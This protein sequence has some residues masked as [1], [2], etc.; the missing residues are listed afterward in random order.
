M[1]T[2]RRKLSIWFYW[3]IPLLLVATWY[4]TRSLDVD[5]YWSDEV[6]TAQRAGIAWYAPVASIAE[7]WDRTQTVSDQLPLY[8]ILVGLWS[9]VAGTTPF[10]NRALS[11]FFGII[12]IATTFQIGKRLSG[13]LAGFAAALL[14][15]SSA[16]YILFLHE[17]RTYTWVSCLIALQLWF[18][19]LIIHG[20]RNWWVQAGL[21]LCVAAMLYSYYTSIII[22]AS[23]CLY[24]LL[25]VRKN[26]EWWRVVMLMGI[27]GIL[28]IPW[29]PNLANIAADTGRNAIRTIHTVSAIDGIVNMASAFSNKNNAALLFLL[30]F[31]LNL[32][33]KA[34]RF[35][36]FINISVLTLLVLLNQPLGLLVNVRYSLLIWL[37]L[38][39]LVGLGVEQLVKVGVPLVL[40]LGV[41]FASGFV[42]VTNQ[43]LTDEYD[44]PV[45]Y[46]PFDTLTDITR[47]YEQTGDTLVFITLI[48][49]D[50]WE[51]GHERN[52]MPHYFYGSPMNSVFMEDVRNLP[53]AA[54]LAEGEQVTR[55]AQRVWLTY[56]PKL[57]SWRIGMFQDMLAENGFANCG[58]F[59]DNDSLYLDLYAHPNAVE[60][61]P[62]FRFGDVTE[63]TIAQLTPLQPLPPFVHDT[64]TLIHA[65]TLSDALPRNVYSLAVHIV[66]AN[67]NLVAQADYGLPEAS[68]A[69]TTNM[70]DVRHLPAG[71]YRVQAFVYAW[72]NGSHLP[73]VNNE[74]V[75]LGTFEVR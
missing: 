75:I 67:D 38:A 33:S 30:L 57:R 23:I 6:L 53:D 18:Y 11:L 56:A 16:F 49:G 39:L 2:P 54:F 69:C 55:N 46:L 10:A 73:D 65:W 15:T 24:H 31:T 68:F 51:G 60:M 20:K 17:M 25:M 58:N 47:Q 5:P 29:L 14:L 7:I 12:A 48:E 8:Y 1:Q 59:A 3:M 71:Q 27:A 50:D 61:R 64:L 37:P 4:G 19:W 45:R 70:V 26:R 40:V 22:T 62:A 28:F 74:D 13:E 35:V 42:S 34:H 32:R 44:L 41:I 63:D 72:Q 9:K 21:V 43:R 52:V 36:W 66:D